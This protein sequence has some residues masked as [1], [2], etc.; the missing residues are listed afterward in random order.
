M[1]WYLNVLF[2]TEKEN[3]RSSTYTIQVLFAHSNQCDAPRKWSKPPPE[4]VSSSSF[5]LLQE[6]VIPLYLI[7]CL[8]FLFLGTC[9]ALAISYLCSPQALTSCARMRT[10]VIAR[11]YKWYTRTR[12]C[13]GYGFFGSVISIASFTGY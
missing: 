12:S 7:N 3:S 8:G 1:T 13:D 2:V 11:V 9:I 5:S 4:V 6:H 10:T